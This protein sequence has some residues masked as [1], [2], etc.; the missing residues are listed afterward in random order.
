MPGP[1]NLT[2]PLKLDAFV[3]NQ[4]VCEG[5]PS[6]AALI[7]PLTQPNYSYLRLDS[8]YIQSDILDHVDLHN[9]CPWQTNPRLVDLGQAAGTLRTARLGVYLHWMMPRFYRS[10]AAATSSATATHARERQRKGFPARVAP[11][12]DIDNSTPQFRPLPN[13]WLV[14]R[15]LNPN[16]PTTQPQ[17]APIAPVQAWIVESDRIWD[18]NDP[19]L[20]D[21]DL[22][23]DVSPY[24]TT[25]PKSGGAGNVSI[26][27]QAQAFIG[28]KVEAR[29]WQETTA[30]RADLTVAS[31]SNHLFPDYQPHCSNVFSTLDT[32]AYQTQGANGQ[33]IDANLTAASAS[34]YVLGWHS[35]PQ[36]DPLG[37]LNPSANPPVTRAARLSS[38]SMTLDGDP[39][40]WPQDIQD[41]MAAVDPAAVM[42][43][44]AMYDVVWDVTKPPPNVPANQAAQTLTESMPLAIG[45][46]PMDSLLAYIQAHQLSDLEKD[47]WALAPLL[48][49][50]DEGVQAQRAA[51]D[52]LQ[53]WNYSRASGGVHWHFHNA[54][55]S[56]AQ[57]PSSTDVAN[58]EALNQAQRLLDGTARQ[59]ERLQ[60]D[61]FSYWW[62]YVCLSNSERTQA[63]YPL[64]A[65][66][67]KYTALTNLAT[68][69]Q[70]TVTALST[71]TKFSQ[72]PKAGVLPEFSQPR[73]PTLL[74]GGIQAGWP[75]DYLDNLAVRLDTMTIQPSPPMPDLTPYC[76]S[77][78][79]PALQ[80]T[81]SALVLE[82]VALTPG[83][84]AS[85]S[86]KVAHPRDG[87]PTFPPLYHDHG[88]H[89]DASGPLRDQW[90]QTQ[91]WFPLF[92]EWEAEYYH[93]PWDAWQLQDAPTEGS[94]DK[95]W[96]LGINPDVTLSDPKYS[97]DMRKLSGRILLLPQPNFSLQAAIADLFNTTPPDVINKYLPNPTDQQTV[98]NDTYSLPLMSGPLDSFTAGLLTLS[99]GTHIKPNIRVP[100]QPLEPLSDATLLPFT[101][102][103][104]N[105]LGAS[106]ELT[107]YGTLV[108]FSDSGG[109]GLPPIP[110]KPATHGQF[111]FSKLNVVDKFG[112]AICAIDPRYGHAADQ[113]VFP[114]VS[115]YFAPQQLSSGQCNTVLAPEMPG[116]C[117][118]AQVPPAIN[119]HSR[120][121]G[122]FLTQD[123]R[124]VAGD[125]TYSYWRPVT[126]WESPVWG[127]I[128]LNYADYGIQLFLPDG[129][130]YREVRVA[131]PTA[132]PTTAT[133]STKWLPFSPPP[134]T[135]DTHQLDNLVLQLTSDDKYL[136]AF[137]AM[138]GDSLDAA[139]S[140]APSAYGSFLSA[141]VGRPLA[142][143]NAGWSLE[144]ASVAR[145]DQ[146]TLDSSTGRALDTGL[147]PNAYPSGCKEVY[148]FPVKLGDQDRACDGLVGYFNLAKT[149][150]PLS[151]GNELDLSTIYTYYAAGDTSGTILTP[152]GGAKY[153]YPALPAFWLDPT[154]YAQPVQTP[155]SNY[156]R[157]WNEKLAVFGLIMDPFVPVTACSGAVQ[158]VGRLQLPPWVWQRALARMT[159]FFH[160]GPVLATADVQP[161]WDPGKTLP[162]AYSFT[163]P[164][165]DPT[166]SGSAVPFPSL[167]LAQWAWLQPF[168]DPASTAE[169]YM[170]LGLANVDS[171]P[172]FEKG[173]Y[174]ALEGYL[175]LKTPLL[176]ELQ[177]TQH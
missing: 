163:P 21:K 95:Q 71:G 60:W 172:G 8:G 118:F 140:S 151:P 30:T 170:A 138:L 164:A 69:Q 13:R 75:D 130:F 34:Y 11:E 22:Q 79:P 40:S 45:T 139:S 63:S 173:P 23:V 17:G 2:I 162:P 7:A 72:P 121:N 87:D 49:A 115:D 84:G 31:A 33:S 133:A 150:P 101:P 158:P 105:M 153:T 80:P 54:P 99:K 61:M 48:R 56:A 104:L 46:T 74:I 26:E 14:I 55:D 102:D 51:A 32:F 73:D 132:P 174:T 68:D 125:P 143:V 117:E 167:P 43:H 116:S 83:T 9:A 58:L 76:I 156:A 111:R 159:A 86:G 62:K 27:D 128:V 66:M 12:A 3:F 161:Y 77:V 85:S 120:L 41:W 4:S 29:G 114:C 28:Y 53:N 15:T 137:L 141:L 169:K 89:G 142:L 70:N 35:N 19:L 18:I 90:G 10:G 168:V 129:T 39:A 176:H 122:V 103:N 106:S 20:D 52:E 100:G 38:L 36:D 44:G 146:S 123:K 59:L 97:A 57:D 119:Q 171:K 149:P 108:L 67:A 78:L 135:Q 25:K 92:I 64:D 88:K 5:Q 148:N 127:W 147:I 136:L 152:I 145:V 155:A 6:D 165:P 24:I 93:I 160:L 154:T 157:D 50:Q 109:A 91:P 96:L 110:F 37:S 126:E 112:Q 94:L 47:L 175:Q 81:A 16:A 113:T 131:A 124:Y 98:L 107:P 177:P 65:L 166:V 82:F 134:L 144:L 1:A 42:C